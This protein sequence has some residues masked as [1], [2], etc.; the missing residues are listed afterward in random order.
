MIGHGHVVG[1][2]PAAPVGARAQ[3]LHGV[4]HGCG[5][6]DVGLRLRGVDSRKAQQGQDAVCNVARRAFRP[7]VEGA[8]VLTEQAAKPLRRFGSYHAAFSRRASS[9]S[10]AT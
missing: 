4:S 8:I 10:L 1:S 9:I 6:Y 2:L 3:R 7:R 5:F